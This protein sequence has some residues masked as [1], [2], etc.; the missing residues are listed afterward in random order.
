[1]SIRT[2][3]Q[4]RSSLALATIA[5]QWIKMSSHNIHTAIS[6]V[7]TKSVQSFV[8]DSL[9]HLKTSRIFLAQL[10]AMIT[11]NDEYTNWNKFVHIYQQW[12]LAVT[13][14]LTEIEKEVKTSENNK[15]HKSSK[16]SNWKAQEEKREGWLVFEKII[17]IIIFQLKSLAELGIPGRCN[18]IRSRIENRTPN[19]NE[20]W[21]DG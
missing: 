20:I 18:W 14:S 10:S 7:K 1:M 8:Q 17:Y 21:Y 12:S 6:N 19:W 4:W 16:L 15:I 2:T 13:N 3:Y 11:G 5:C 9:Q